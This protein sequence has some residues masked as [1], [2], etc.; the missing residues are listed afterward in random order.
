MGLY[1]DKLHEFLSQPENFDYAWEIFEAMP[2]LREKLKGEALDEFEE[3]VAPSVQGK[4]W[5]CWRAPGRVGISKPSWNRMFAVDLWIGK[6][7]YQ[8][9]GLW[10]DKD[11]DNLKDRYD[12]LLER[13][14]P[15]AKACRLKSSG[16]SSLWYVSIGTNYQ[17]AAEMRE[18]LPANRQE[19]LQGYWERLWRMAEVF[20]PVVD[21]IVRDLGKG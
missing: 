21:D 13:T 14:R 19:L 5:E 15:A 6:Q 7:Y 3:L 20:G 10:H 16:T 18:L 8:A 9:V 12:D 2:V 17:T 11:H 1:E 4:G